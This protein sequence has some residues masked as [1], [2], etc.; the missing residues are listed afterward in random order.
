MSWGVA[1]GET[2]VA[3]HPSSSLLNNDRSWRPLLVASIAQGRNVLKFFDR[4]V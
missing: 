2:L 4:F 3:K 1:V